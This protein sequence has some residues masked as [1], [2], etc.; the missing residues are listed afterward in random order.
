MPEPRAGTDG[1]AL[2][3]AR[4]GETPPG[5]PETKNPPAGPKAGGGISRESALHPVLTDPVQRPCAECV[6]SDQLETNFR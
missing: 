4:P 2:E 1:P 6:M 3:I 5:A